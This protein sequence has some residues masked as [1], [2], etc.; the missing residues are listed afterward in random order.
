MSF[1]LRW[2]FGTVHTA[3]E[4][5]QSRWTLL[6]GAGG[7]TLAATALGFFIA[8]VLG[9]STGTCWQLMMGC[10]AGYP[11]ANLLQM[12]PVIALAPL[13]NIWF[14]HGIAGVSAS[15]AIVAIFPV[16]ANTVDGLRG[17]DPKL[18][19]YSRSTMLQGG[20]AGGI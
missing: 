4:S 19:S 16:I 11:L 3:D 12:V 10:A 5:A 18:K 9:L 20:N 13:L 15:A 7:R 8:V 14:G 6:L 17:G 2:K 1:R